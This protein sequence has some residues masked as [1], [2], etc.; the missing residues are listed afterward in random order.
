MQLIFSI[1]VM[2]ISI[3][4]SCLD[5]LNVDVVLKCLYFFLPQ[6]HQFMSGRIKI[7]KDGVPVSTKD[8][9]PL[10]Y[11]YDEPGDFDQK[12]GTFGLD[13]FQLPNAVCPDQFVC[14]VEEVELQSVADFSACIDAMNCHM[15][16][17]MTTGV[18]AASQMALFIHQMIPH[19]QNAIN[20]AKTLL[21]ENVLVCEDLADEDNQDCIMEA[22]IREIVNTQNH[23]IQKMLS[24]LDENDYPVTDNCDVEIETVKTSESTNPPVEAPAQSPIATVD[25]NTSG[26]KSNN[27][28]ATAALILV[29]ACLTT[30]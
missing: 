12:C 23:Q 13:P 20:M 10:G 3:A 6:I 16:S 8:E 18:K 1:S 25:L 2:Y 19:H 7:L 14:G 27:F 29:I 9:P 21:H 28:R 30:Y 15:L 26:S 4:E 24:Y 17:G 22:I 11:A 5:D